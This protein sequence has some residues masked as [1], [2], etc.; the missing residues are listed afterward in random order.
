MFNWKTMYNRV[1]SNLNYEQLVLGLK[2]KSKIMIFICDEAE[3]FGG[4]QNFL[5]MEKIWLLHIL[6]LPIHKSSEKM[7]INW[8]TMYNSVIGNLYSEQLVLGLK[9]KF[10]IMMLIS[11]ETEKLGA[12]KTFIQWRKIGY[13]TFYGGQ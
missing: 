9:W 1:I 6:W 12:F 7:M 2:W 5:L 11:D 10:K 3:K 8:K 4:I 13:F